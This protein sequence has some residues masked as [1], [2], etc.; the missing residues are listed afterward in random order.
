MPLG[1]FSCLIV[2]ARIS[3]TV[4]RMDILLPSLRR[5]SFRLSPVSVVFVDAVYLFIYIELYLICS[6]VLI[7]A[8]QQSDSAIRPYVFF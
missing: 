6:V 2:L 5:R 3:D 8:P 1:F 4:L 7:S